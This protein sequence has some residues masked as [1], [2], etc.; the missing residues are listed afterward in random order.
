MEK[1]IAK[2]VI[3]NSI[4]PKF[5]DDIKNKLN[6]F[7]LKY[8]LKNTNIDKILYEYLLFLYKK[9]S[10]TTTLYDSNF[11]IQT[12]DIFEDMTLKQISTEI[13]NKKFSLDEYINYKDILF[14]YIDNNIIITDTAGM[15]KTTFSKYI[16]LELLK[17]DDLKKFPI[18]IELRKM[19]VNTTLKNVFINEINKVS[20]NKIDEDIFNHLFSQNMFLFI[21]DGYDEIK[22]ENRN[23]ITNEISDFS[24]NHF[25]N[26]IILTTRKQQLLPKIY[27]KT[28][29]EFIKLDKKKIASILLKMDKVYN[30]DYGLR[31]IKHNKFNELDF[32]LFETPLMVSL[33]Y[34]HYSYSKNL[35]T[36]ILN[37]YMELYDALYK[38]H[39][40]TKDNFER[41]KLSKLNYTD[42]KTFFSTFCFL[43]MY[44]NNTFFKNKNDLFSLFK[45]S[46]NMS[47]IKLNDYDNFLEDVLV[48][49]PIMIKD[50]QEYKFAHKT[51]LEY[52]TAECLNLQTYD[53]LFKG[54]K[55][56]NR[57]NTFKKSFEFLYELN[58]KL[59]MKEIGNDFLRKFNNF[60]SHSNINND[61][62]LTIKFLFKRLNF[63]ITTNKSDLPKEFFQKNQGSKGFNYQNRSFRLHLYYEMN[64]D[65]TF[66][67][68]NFISRIV[69]VKNISD[70][71]IE[72]ILKYNTQESYDIESEMTLILF[73]NRRFINMLFTEIGIDIIFNAIDMDKVNYL[74]Q[75]HKYSD[76]EIDDFLN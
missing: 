46:E 59:F 42:F 34:V 39:D 36:N 47:K 17:N 29:Y 11:S 31:I 8:K 54:I 58:K 35:D 33:L 5:K 50:G 23:V 68:S 63:A 49:V 1:I 30:R 26:A 41:V 61:I 53:N 57:L 70:F 14:R 69:S 55:S 21:L 40:S 71:N 60:S 45:S 16:V 13:R 66:L 56:K 74:L 48:N 22:E 7:Y 52:F 10:N 20:T 24:V 32:T 51:I 9:C 6:K 62:K 12:R 27:Q 25:N 64:D 2:Q 65:I 76:V 73:K 37:F 38:G 3:E 75:E 4:P 43:T 15:G 19:D 28:I 67:P 72:D 18:F 44:I